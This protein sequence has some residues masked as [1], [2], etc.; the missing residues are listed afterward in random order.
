MRIFQCE[1]QGLFPS[2]FM[3]M[4]LM[5][6]ETFYYHGLFL[7]LL[8]LKNPI[9]LIDLISSETTVRCIPK[10]LWKLVTPLFQNVIVSLMRL[11][12]RKLI[13]GVAEVLQDIQSWTMF[14]FRH[15]IFQS[16]T[17]SECG[18]RYASLKRGQRH[19]GSWYH[20]EVEH[21]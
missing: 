17:Q 4:Q 5:Q 9:S 3:L 18:V 20:H 21:S 13:Q 19:A 6:K 1:W 10:R 11:A 15:V 2:W 8:A 14:L 16:F 12:K 7:G